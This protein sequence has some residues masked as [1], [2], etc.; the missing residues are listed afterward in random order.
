MI[1]ITPALIQI[2]DRLDDDLVGKIPAAWPPANDG[3]GPVVDADFPQVQAA[4][5][6]ECVVNLARVKEYVAQQVGGNLDTA[7]FDAWQDLMRGMQSGL[8]MLGKTRAESASR[9]SR[10]T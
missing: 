9:A 2:E 8:A 7:G 5:L 10:R 3:S 6:R 1:G 4:V